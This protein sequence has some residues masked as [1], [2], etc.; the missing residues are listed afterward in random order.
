MPTKDDTETV[1]SI[2]NLVRD[3]EKQKRKRTKG[4]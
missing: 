4:K 3:Y 1:L 2:K